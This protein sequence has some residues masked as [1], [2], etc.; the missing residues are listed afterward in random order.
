MLQCPTKNEAFIDVP[1]ALWGIISPFKSVSKV[2]T[3]VSAK[4]EGKQNPIQL[5]QTF[6]TR[7]DNR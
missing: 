5:Q 1:T 2:V 6:S 7:L 3:F 4:K